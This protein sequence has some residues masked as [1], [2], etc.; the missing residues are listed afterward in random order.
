MRPRYTLAPLIASAALALLACGGEAAPGTPTPPA[1]GEDLGAEPGAD[2]RPDDVPA[3]EEM[4]PQAPDMPDPAPADM[5]ADA[6]DGEMG[7]PPSRP[8]MPGAPDMGSPPPEEDMR[9]GE[10]V[11]T[12]PLG[13]ARP[14]RVFVPQGYDNSRELPLVLLLHGYSANGSAQDFYFQLSRRVDDGD[15]ILVI[16][17]GTVDANGNQFWNATGA[18]CDFL[19]TG[20]DDVAYL[21]GLLEE[22][23]A[24]FRVDTGRVY[25]W[26]HSN[27]GFMSYTLACRAADKITGV[28]SLAGTTFAQPED[29]DPSQPVAVLHAHGTLDDVILYGGGALL[30][31]SY[32]G[33]EATA[34]RWASYNGCDPS[35]AEAP[36]RDRVGNVPGAETTPSQWSGCQGPSSVTLWRMEGAAHI[37]TLRR[38]TTPAI[39]EHL[40]AIDRTP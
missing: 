23:T 12:S 16:P 28:F 1:S 32:P 34:R 9:A 37:P 24:R 31:Q 8:D 30:G 38:E 14:A 29:C 33:A 25:A 2:M 40:F 7:Q 15:F 6:P 3:D 39:L 18:C 11:D 26:G 21:T 22:A 17:E 20:V 35:P 27:G 13:G 4:G 10:P 5:P 19:D 36:A